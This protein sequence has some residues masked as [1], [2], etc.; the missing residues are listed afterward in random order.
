MGFNKATVSTLPLEMSETMNG[1]WGFSLTDD[2]FKSTSAL[3]RSMVGA[4]GR[5]ANFL[6]NTGPM[7]NGV[8]QPE[9]VQTL[10]EIGRWTKQFG[11]SI[12]GTRGGPVPPKPWGVTTEKDDTIYVHILDWNDPILFVPITGDLGQA[13]LLEN[14]RPT[15]YRKVAGGIELLDAAKPTNAIDRVIAIRRR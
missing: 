9:N 11:S 1:T 15:A 5:N 6:L 10:E 12:Y 4:A 13:T 8:L 14:G 7:P 3:I 2:E